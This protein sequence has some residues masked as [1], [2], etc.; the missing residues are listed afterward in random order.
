MEPDTSAISITLNHGDGTTEQILG[1]DIT[2]VFNRIKV[3]DVNGDGF[4]D[5][6]A[7]VQ[8]EN[9]EILIFN[10]MGD[11]SLAAP[12]TIATTGRGG[13]LLYL[14]DWDGDDQA[15]I[16]W[17]K[18]KVDSERQIHIMFQTPDPNQPPAPD[19]APG[20]VPTNIDTNAE[21]AE[22]EGAISNIGSG[23]IEV[24]GIKVWHTSSTVLQFNDV[25]GFAVGLPV[26]VKGNWTTDGQIVATDLEVN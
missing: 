11:G 24:N 1:P 4:L 9:E 26:Q 21:T 13:Q 6:V 15:D 23:Y 18:N 10:G 16:A 5:V 22:I 14:N 2:G 19:P 12:V 25:S 3:A 17:F 8:W 20:N 7:E